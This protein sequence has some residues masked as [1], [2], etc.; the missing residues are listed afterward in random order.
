MLRPAAAPKQCLPAKCI[1]FP[2]GLRVKGDDL[3]FWQSALNSRLA[4][5]RYGTRIDDLGKPL[6]EPEAK[7]TGEKSAAADEIT[8]VK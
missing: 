2:G 7:A 6:V 4:P 3:G 5:N 8:E 1:Y